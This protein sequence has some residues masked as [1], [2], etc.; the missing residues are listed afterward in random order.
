MPRSAGLKQ[1]AQGR[2]SGEACDCDGGNKKEY[3]S[4]PCTYYLKEGK[5][6]PNTQ[7]EMDPGLKRTHFFRHD[8]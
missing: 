4:S 8:V 3:E 2:N 5:T 6:N 1:P 7:R